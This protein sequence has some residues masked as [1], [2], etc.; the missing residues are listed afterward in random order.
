M[1][2]LGIT[3][4]LALL[5]APVPPLRVR[6][7]AVA[8]PCVQSALRAFA[9]PAGGVAVDVGSVVTPGPGDVLVASAVELTRALETG[10]AE[11]NTDV[12]IARVPWVLQARGG[13]R[14]IRGAKD[15]EGSR[16]EVAVPAIPAAYEAFR[17]AAKT[18]GTPARTANARELR[19]AP[20]TLVPLSLAVPGDR[21]GV[22]LPSVVIRAALGIEPSRRAEAQAFL[23]FLAS[24]AGKEAFAACRS[25]P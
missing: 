10:T 19:E 20:V 9:A 12:D 25:T 3:M 4:L 17:W 21:F 1:R 7:T 14:P 2:A 22:D 13:A 5:A 8:A 18:T 15:L 6:T 23:T 16:V 24:P 11:A